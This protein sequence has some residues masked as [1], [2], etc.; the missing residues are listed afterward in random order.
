[1][2]INNLVRGGPSVG[3]SN[4]RPPTP[5]LPLPDFPQ[6]PADTIQE[7]A[8]KLAALEILV[9]RKADADQIR[10][11]IAIS[12]ELILLQAKDIVIAGEVT[13]VDLLKDWN[14]VAGGSVDSSITLIRG[15][16]IRT[17][18]ITSNNY[19]ASAG[20][21]FDLDNGIVTIGG[22]DNPSLYFEDGDLFLSGSI[23]AE[24]IVLTK[25]KTL[26]Q[27]ADLAD[28]A[29]PAGDFSDVLNSTLQSGVDG[30]LAGMTGD[31]RLTVTGTSIIAS[32]ADINL[33]GLGSGYSGDIRTGVAIT[34][35]GIA[36]GFN[37]K[38]DGAW[39]NAIS[40]GATG[41]VAILGTLSAGSVITSSVT[42]D[43]VALS[44]VSS[45]AATGSNHAAAIG[46]PHSTLLTEIAGDL[47][48]LADGSTYFRTTATQVAGATRGYN[49]L[50]SNYDYIRG[51]STQRIVVS[52]ANPTN[53]VVIDSSG[54]RGYS[55]GVLKFL[56][57]TTGTAVF[58]G[59]ITGASGTF[60]G[61]LNTAGV[62]KATGSTTSAVGDACIVGETATAFRIGV[63]GVSSGSLGMGV[64]GS[65]S[66]I[67]GSGVVASKSGSGGFALVVDHQAGGTAISIVNGSITGDAY[68]DDGVFINSSDSNL[69]LGLA[70]N[71]G[72]TNLIMKNGVA[73][74]RIADQII[75]LAQ[76]SGA[77]KSTLHLIVEEDVVAGTGPLAGITDQL[78]IRVN[79][80]EFW[81]P[82]VPV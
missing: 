47:D 62:C 37:R 35:T 10:S 65:A 60:S 33:S 7:I 9:E 27:I 64:R 1:M 39:V 55:G 82:V 68:F 5:T 53:G 2:S 48:D 78:R 63:A 71:T 66:G 58:S 25:D 41:D 12:D 49:A 81:L 17:G 57:D 75:M 6:D 18:I 73:G 14:G 19:S 59:S 20:T 79:G 28:G 8:Q 26:G 24:S 51:L 38:S 76:D 22:S 45:N 61:D 40:I 15:G 80:T 77:S 46:N 69:V 54:L 13:F 36:M 72:Q 44:T 43:G 42:V 74:G 3:M 21:A 29:L 16:V 34:G 23:T 50:D 52:E 30:I 32:H 11:L 56:I 70:T 31:Y 67:G 4:Q